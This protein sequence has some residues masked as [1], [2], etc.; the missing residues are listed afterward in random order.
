MHPAST[1]PPVSAAAAAIARRELD[2]PLGA[3]TLARSARGLVGAWFH[4]QKH[5]PP[6][7]VARDVAA[8]VDPVLDEAAARLCDYFAGDPRGFDGLA[9]DLVGT[10]FQRAVWQQLLGIA[11]GSTTTYGTLARRLGQPTASRAVGAAVGRNPLGIIVPCHRVVGQ[12]GSLTGY[13][14]GLPRKTA[15]LE[16][17][18][19]MRPRGPEQ[20]AFAF[21]GHPA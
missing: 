9:L 8:G 19:A 11:R 3:L 21:A 13:A 6:A 18:R 15:L 20:V 2:T 7:L 4:D 1:P 10:A 14:G 17:E 16:I 5:R 12:D